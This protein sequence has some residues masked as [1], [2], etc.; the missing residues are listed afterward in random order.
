MR[1]SD[2]EQADQTYFEAM[3][4]IPTQV[5]YGFAVASIIAS[6]VLFMMG[7]RHWSLFVGQWPPT[8]I[9]MALMNKLLRPSRERPGDMVREASEAMSSHR[10]SR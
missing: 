3:E 8:F 1:N 2:L 4:A 6:A 7:R 5:Y 9:A 10:G